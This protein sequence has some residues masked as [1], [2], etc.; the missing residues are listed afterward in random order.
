MST[1]AATAPCPEIVSYLEA[2][3][4]L[5]TAVLTKLAGEAVAIECV[6]K[7]PEGLPAASPEDVVLTIKTSGAWT[8]RLA[9]RLTTADAL[10][11]A[12]LIAG[13]EP[14][15]ALGDAER[16]KLLEW[17]RAIAA[18]A[19][20]ELKE[21]WGELAVAVE[22]GSIE[23][24]LAA[25]LGCSSA[26]I[27]SLVLGLQLDAPL[28]EALSAWRQ[29]HPTAEATASAT[30]PAQTPGETA[31]KPSEAA[32]PGD[33]TAEKTTEA[34]AAIPKQPVPPEPEEI[35]TIPDSLPGEPGNLDLL[36]DVELGVTLRFG[37]RRMLLR[38][39]L[40]LS[41]GAVIEL[42]RLVQ[43]PVDL[44]LDGKLIARGEVVVVDGNYGL[45]V[46]EVAEPPHPPMS[47]PAEAPAG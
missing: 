36:L 44:L 15:S 10:R 23:G 12:G 42:D 37:S 38:E 22:P 20:A 17:L 25:W 32:A 16:G 45:R 24:A 8:G 33:Q 27:G 29:A 14:A 39:V 1:A 4:N 2:W 3:R 6:W 43:E 18:E 41:A 28:L 13:G 9:V 19:V 47:A 11:L 31:E 35:E 34:A 26:K 5:F 21:N 30:T 46:S 40:E 7:Q